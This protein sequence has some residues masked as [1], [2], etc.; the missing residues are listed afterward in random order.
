MPRAID[1][2]LYLNVE[3]L[4]TLP[5]ANCRLPIELCLT[6]RFQSTIANWKSAIFLSRSLLGIEILSQPV[7][8]EVEGQDRQSD[9]N[10][11]EDQ[12]MWGRLQG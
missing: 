2:T 9:R 12:R 1:T 10:S 11:W 3:E 6:L 8:D 4:S 7:A 5:I